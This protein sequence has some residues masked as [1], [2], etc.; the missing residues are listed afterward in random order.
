MIS[1]EGATGDDANARSRPLAGR[2]RPSP[3]S[4]PAAISYGATGG[5]FAGGITIWTRLRRRPRHRRRHPLDVR[6]QRGHDA[7]HRPRRRQRHR[8]PERGRRRL[9]RPQHAG[10]VREH[11]AA[12][13]AVLRRRLQHARRR[14]GHGLV[15]RSGAVRRRVHGD[16][17]AE[18]GRADDQ[19][20]RRRHGRN[21]PDPHLADVHLHRRHAAGDR[22]GHQGLRGR[23]ALHGSYTPVFGSLVVVQT[24]ATASY[25]YPQPAPAD[26]DYRRRLRLVAAARRLRR[27]R[28]RHADRR[29][30]QRRPR[31]RPR[32]DPL[33]RRPERRRARRTA[34][35]RS[36]R[37]RAS[38]RSAAAAASATRPSGRR[39]SPTS[40][41]R[42]TRASTAPTRSSA[43]A[44]TTS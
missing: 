37:V 5:D 26:N 2:R 16:P 39:R 29:L 21:R 1:D 30:G 15:E 31:R 10:R 8:Q 22:A 36:A 32:P 13:A 17:V 35:S 40:S 12:P 18:R 33:P 34:S 4:R 41:S 19:P 3:A 11:A 42:S 14:R 7:Q 25:T 38:R 6:R 43:T 20:S 27:R 9:L 28:Q 23:H 44:A 24:T